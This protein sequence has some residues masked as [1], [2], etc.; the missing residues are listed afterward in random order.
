MS[1]TEFPKADTGG[2]RSAGKSNTW[3]IILVL[4]VVLGILALCLCGGLAAYI[5]VAP[6][7]RG[8]EVAPPMEGRREIEFLEPQDPQP[9]SD[10]PPDGT[11]SD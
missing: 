7:E 8:H 11:K 3:I 9:G 6:T 1:Q 2:S 10:S 5:L 4:V